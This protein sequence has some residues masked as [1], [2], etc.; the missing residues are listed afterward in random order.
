[1]VFI[2][3]IYFK[4]R[5]LESRGLRVLLS[6]T[7][8]VPRSQTHVKNGAKN[9]NPNFQGCGG[10]TVPQ[11][12]TSF[13]VCLAVSAWF[14]CCFFWVSLAPLLSLIYLVWYIFRCRSFSFSLSCHNFFK[15]QF[16]HRNHVFLWKSR[17]HST[18]VM[19]FTSCKTAIRAVKNAVENAVKN[20]RE[21]IYVLKLFIFIFHGIF[22]GI[23]HS[24]FHSIFH[25]I[26]HGLSCSLSWRGKRVF[27]RNA[28]FPLKTCFAWKTWYQSKK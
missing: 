16:F 18:E 26:F 10:D 23:F 9:K 2:Y 22:H 17:F 13:L 14:Q 4:A 19:F 20:G 3:S 21:K 6:H 1:M 27:W 24:I 7:H 25:G 5:W 12:L 28:W 11:T 15:D 8:F